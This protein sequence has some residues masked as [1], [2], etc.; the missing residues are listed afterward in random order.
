MTT[1]LKF[2]NYGFGQN[3]FSLHPSLNKKR[4]DTMSKQ[5]RNNIT[6]QV[7]D[8]IYSLIIKYAKK[9]KLTISKLIRNILSR[10]FESELSN[11]LKCEIERKKTIFEKIKEKTDGEVVALVQK[12]TGNI[13]DEPLSCGNFKFNN[14]YEFK[15]NMIKI[16]QKI[17]G[18]TFLIYIKSLQGKYIKGLQNS[19]YWSSKV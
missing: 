11:I 9:Q 19:V 1:G 13:N 10:Y 16:S 4:G 5:N 12:I 2:H 17:G 15:E 14:E 7:N 8:E 18:G 3:N 6:V